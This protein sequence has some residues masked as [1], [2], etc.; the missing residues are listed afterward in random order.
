[1]F[2][3][4]QDRLGP[5]RLADEAEL[6]AWVEEQTGQSIASWRRISGGNRCHSWAIEFSVPSVQPLYLRYQPPRPSSAEPYTVWREARIYEALKETDVTA[7]RLCAVHPE[8]Q[9]IL[10]EL[11]PGRA[12][13]RSLNDESERQSIA[14][15]FVEAIAQLHRTPF[16]VAAIP[17][18]TELMSIADCV[19]DELKI[20]RAMYAET[21][22]PDPL[23]EFAMDWLEDNVPE[24]AGRPVLVHGDAGPGNFLFQNG[25]M[26]ALLDWELA[27][28]GDPMEDL[29]WF[30]MRSVMEPVPDFAAAILH[31]QA[32]GGAVLDLARIHYH[33]VFVSTRV[34]IIRHRNVT[35][36][37]GNSIISR[38]L[39]RRL[40]VDALAEASGVTLLQSP[41][42]EAAPTPRTELY[43]GVIASLR[44]EIAT[45][46]NDPHIIAA[47]KNNAKVLKYLREADRLG[48]LVCQ[49]ELAD[50]SALLGSPLPSVEDGRAQL[51]AGLRDRNIPFDT[52]LR[53]FAQR[54]ANDAQMA[55]LASGGLA[56]RKL[57]SLDS[58]EGK[59]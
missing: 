44:E 43:D 49:R 56:S 21:A 14:L 5:E 55:A 27:H 34:V 11:R 41:P 48:A 32:A 7:P 22:M 42:L 3:L 19:R 28:P 24:P 18:L 50:L 30:S 47:S 6:K 26:T 17:G 23:I 57:P 16:P 1:M 33:R 40:L 12:D 37:P 51:I 15:E 9:A 45:A 20:W 13:Y 31:Y 2:R 38:A 4:Q 52:A 53:F 59:K 35:G 46:T 36:Q 10:T 25:H 58:L 39:N 54:V 8:H 29:A